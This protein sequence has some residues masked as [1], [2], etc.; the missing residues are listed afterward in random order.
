MVTI[1]M[2]MYICIPYV[3]VEASPRQLIF[4]RKVT[5]L[6]VLCYFALLFV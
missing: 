5:A 3:H 6:G 2:Y 4:L 1:Y